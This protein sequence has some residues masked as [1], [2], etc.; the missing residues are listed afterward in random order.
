[1]F[2][3]ALL[4]LLAIGVA[5]GA[6]A[7]FAPRRTAAVEAPAHD[8]APARPQQSPLTE[9][10]RVDTVFAMGSLDSDEATRRLTEALDDPSETVALAAAHALAASGRADALRAY[11]DAHPGDRAARLANTID[12]MHAS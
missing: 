4:V 5:L 8:P 9:A 6:Y 11:F 1:V 10:Q 7:I 2:L 3:T 12:W